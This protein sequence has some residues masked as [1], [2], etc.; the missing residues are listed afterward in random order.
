MPDGTQ[1]KL[2]HL[3]I[4]HQVGD[5]FRN[6]ITKD[7]WPIEKCSRYK[8]GE[9]FNKDSIKNNKNEEFSTLLKN[10]IVYG[11]GGIVPDYFVPLDTTELVIISANLLKGIFN[12]FALYW[13]NK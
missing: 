6:L 13:V 5:A 11:G 10:R 12:Q 7:L 9:S 3:N 1:V 8:S 4:I 2:Q